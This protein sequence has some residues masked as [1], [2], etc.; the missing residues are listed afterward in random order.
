MYIF[1]YAEEH[2]YHPAQPDVNYFETDTIKVKET[3]TLQQVSAYTG[4]SLEELQFLN[5]AYKLDI[6][7]YVE[8][9]NYYL[10]LP[11]TAVWKTM[12]KLLSE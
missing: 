10:R 12:I 6:I 2:G 8:D 11:V 3:I 7:P 5:P 1:E 4:V 9:E